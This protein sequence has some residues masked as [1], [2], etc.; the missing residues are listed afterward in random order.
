[1]QGKNQ[2]RY[3]SESRESIWT[4]MKEYSSTDFN[5]AWEASP[6]KYI[7]AFTMSPGSCKASAK[8]TEGAVARV[9]V[10][11]YR[12]T[13]RIRGRVLSAGNETGTGVNAAINVVSGKNVTQIWPA[14]AGRQQI[15]S[16]DQVGYSTNVDEVQVVPGEKI[17]FEVHSNGDNPANPVSWTPSVGYIDVGA[18]H[19]LETASSKVR[20]QS[21][22][23]EASSSNIHNQT[24]TRIHYDVP[25]D[26]SRSTR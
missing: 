11:P 1:V 6:T 5:G 23:E 12:G 19:P 16:A 10:A 26:G 15:A 3:E 14:S 24:P 21:R 7:S 22:P 2:W 9:W 8:C 17:R 4:K 20:S 13:V 18:S 25:R